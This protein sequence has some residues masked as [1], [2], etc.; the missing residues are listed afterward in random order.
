MKKYYYILL[1]FAA[2]LSF[3]ACTPEVDDVFSESSAQRVNNS[4][5]NTKELLESAPNGWLMEYYGNTDFGGYNVYAKF[6]DSRVTVQSEM[7][8]SDNETSHY[9]VKQ[10]SGVLLSFDEYNK[11]FHFF[12]DPSLEK[13]GSSVADL[14]GDNGEAFEGDFEFRVLSTSTDSV[15]LKGKKHDSKIVM[16]KVG[17]DFN[18][19]NYL[20]ECKNV[21]AKMHSANYVITSGSDTLLNVAPSRG[22]HMLIGTDSNGEDHKM[23]YVVSPQGLKLYEPETVGGKTF[24]GFNISDN[25]SYT[26]AGGSDVQLSKVI[27]PLSQQ[28]ATGAWNITFSGLSELN[29]KYWSYSLQT[30]LK[31]GEEMQVAVLGNYEFS[32]RYGRNFG[33]TF[34]SGGY[35]GTIVFNRE[36]V[37]DDEI[38]LSY[39]G[40]NV[41]NGDYYLAYFD[42]IYLVYPFCYNKT[43]RT[44]KLTTD[45]VGDPSWILMTDEANPQN[46]IRLTAMGSS[47]A[48]YPYRH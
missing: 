40:T 19:D 30:Q 26:D 21:E 12:S 47:P 46:T 37:S 2:M 39:A 6:K 18:W 45:N 3:S 48:L 7:F 33:L 31:M 27:I 11:I 44:F 16:Y 36:L 10:S 13:Y 34:C 22:H 35:W 14:Y 8:G 43:A 32:S 1:A 5:N 28:I 42:Y 17:S 24:T 4:I 9:S 29:Q 38:T 15:V 25:D 23:P 41:L 20:K